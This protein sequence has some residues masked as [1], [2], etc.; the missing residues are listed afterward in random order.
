MITSD[1]EYHGIEIENNSLP[2]HIVK[3]LNE[4]VGTNKWFVK[5]NW[6]SKVIYF[7]NEKDHLLFL[8]TWGQRG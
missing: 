1:K 8:I 2:E 4:R 7:E 6:G 3:W 5:S